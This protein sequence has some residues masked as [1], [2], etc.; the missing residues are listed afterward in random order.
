VN[1]YLPV[2]I[3]A[4]VLRNICKQYNNWTLKILFGWII[5]M[6]LSE[7]DTKFIDMS[8]VIIVKE[9]QPIEVYEMT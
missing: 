6:N 2:I 3:D 1:I 7:E 9:I 4:L 8:K 5:S